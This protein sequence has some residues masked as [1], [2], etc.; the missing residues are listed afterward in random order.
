MTQKTAFPVYAAPVQYHFA[1]LLVAYDFSEAADSCLKYAVMLA[2]R[3]GS[4]IHL[5][6]VQ[7]LA[8]YASVVEAGPVAMGMF[9]R[10]LKVGLQDLE[11]RLRAQGL[12]CDSVR[13]I[14]CISDTIEGMI[15]E[16]TP[17]LLLFGAYGYGLRDR[18]HL[19]S[20]AEHLLRTIRCPA[21][22]VGPHALLRGHEAP[23]IE[24]ILCA[25][26]S[27]VTPEETLR[28][29]GYFAA[30]TG[31]DL[32]IVHVVDA[33][34]KDVPRNHQEQRCE[35]WCSKLRDR[36]IR[37]NCRVIYGRA[38]DAIAA[39]AVES[40]SSLILFGLH[41]SG[42]RMID[43]PDGVV[44]ATIRQAHCPVMAIPFSAR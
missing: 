35:Q 20:T 44:S 26:S 41:R 31:A 23:P 15:L 8:D 9:Q 29:A 32:E 7:S 10:D 38:D 17:G 6:G 16:H 3:F 21:L 27:L 25:T 1:E 39:R 28:F 14:G 2:G 11:E 30:Q 34:Q 40:K 5:L 33:T 42:N 18:R 24:R 4:L 43:C 19:G 22:V 37:V 12:W 13:R 36:G